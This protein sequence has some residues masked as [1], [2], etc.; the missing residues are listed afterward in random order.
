MM[1]TDARSDLASAQDSAMRQRIRTMYAFLVAFNVLVW[2]WAWLDLRGNGALLGTALLAYSFGLRHALD[3]DHIAAIDNVTR[4]LMQHGGRPVAVGFCFAIGHS[5]VVIVAAIAI[6]F[7]ARSVL[8]SLPQWQA[9]GGVLSSI[10]STLFLLAI[11]LLNIALLIEICRSARHVQANEAAAIAPMKGN[12]LARMFKPLFGG[13]AHSWQMIPLG[14]LFGLGFETATEVALLSTTAVQATQGVH[15]ET[16]LLF[17][18][19]FAAGMLTLDATD[20]VLMLRVY[21]AAFVSPLRKLAYNMMLTMT[22]T[23]L[24]LTIAAIGVAGLL[25]A[26]FHP[27][28]AFWHAMD[29]LRDSYTSLGYVIV[30]AFILSWIGAE[31]FYR[32]KARNAMRATAT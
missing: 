10:V 9:Y 23:L 8:P 32:L 16:V 18:M 29:S 4:K 13:I 30:G 28:G 11:G 5:L 15:M 31:G 6:A 12:A 27:S 26:Y 22:S 14:F 17:P 1:P 25:Q 2:I 21:G 3:A 7:A 19:L 24:A 20:G